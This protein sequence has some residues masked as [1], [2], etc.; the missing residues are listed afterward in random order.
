VISLLGIKPTR[1][2]LWKMMY[3][4]YAIN[5]Q[6]RFKMVVR[7][8]KGETKEVVSDT[9]IKKLPRILNLENAVD[10]NDYY[11]SITQEDESE[12]HRFVSAN[13]IVVWKMRTFAFDPDQVNS[14]FDSRIKGN[15][16][17]I[18]DLR[19]NGGGYVKTL[20]AVAANLFPENM[21]I[22]DVKERKDSDV[23]ESDS[24]GSDAF[25]GKLVV[26]VDHDSASASEILARF[27]Q[28]KER[29]VVIGD[30]TAGFV[31][32]ARSIVNT[33]G[34]NTQIAYGESISDAEVIL[35]DGKS[36]EKVGVIPDIPVLPT[37]EDLGYERDPALAAAFKYLGV[38]VTSADAGKLFPIDWQDGKKGT[39]SYKSRK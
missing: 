19:G 34:V 24:R 29:G 15:S 30:R 26:I 7:T 23:M 5:P 38:E 25:K 37:A 9:Q 31:M 39:A 20:E 22:A 36:I 8:P 32:Q 2:E 33:M 13:D 16:N 28:L 21:K 14:I 4:F 3:Y 11:R 17:L 27:I 35:P 12:S 18:L 6:S 1:S 10:W